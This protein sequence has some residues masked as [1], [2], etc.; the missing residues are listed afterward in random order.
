MEVAKVTGD[1]SF[2]Q[3]S[4]DA[5]PALI[6]IKQGI[7]RRDL[8]RWAYDTC[9]L[10]EK[11]EPPDTTRVFWRD[12]RPLPPTGTSTPMF[13]KATN[14]IIIDDVDRGARFAEPSCEMTSRRC[15]ALNGQRRISLSG[16]LFR[17]PIDPRRQRSRIEEP[18]IT[19]I[20]IHH[21]TL[22][23]QVNS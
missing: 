14:D 18:V 6:S 15:V 7:W 20:G 4:V 12:L 22:S 9:S 10:Q 8:Q 5:Q 11:N 21:T 1:R 16:K 3:S 17:E 13:G 23:S 2:R 19:I